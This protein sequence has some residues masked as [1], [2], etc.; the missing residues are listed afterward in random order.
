MP[1]LR[2][3]SL[4]ALA[5]IATTPAMAAVGPDQSGTAVSDV[6]VTARRLD[7]ARATIEPSLGASVYTLP[8]QTVQA[9]PGG[10]NNSLNQVLLQAPGVAQD[11]FGQLHVRDD[12][13]NLQYRLNN[14]I[15]PEGLSGFGQVLS[16]RLAASTELITGAVPAQYGLR[17][18]GIVNL[19]TKTG[20]FQNAGEASIYGGAHSEIE[21]SFEYGGS[22]GGTNFFVSGSYLHNDLGIESPD[23]SADPLH[24]KTDQ[25]QGFAYVDHILGPQSRISFILG[26][27]DQSFQ[28]PSR[29]GLSSSIDGF[30][31]GDGT[32]LVVDGVS[33]YP[34]ENVRSS[35]REGTQF[36][37]VSYL[38]TWKA[39]TLQVSGFVRYSTLTYRPDF[40]GELLFNGIAQFAAKRDIAGGV[41]V[42]GVYDL[43]D[44]HTLRAGFI[45][46]LDRSRS[47]TLSQVLPVD[48]LGVQ[49]TDGPLAVIDNSAKTEFEGG[50]YL[51]DEWK[52]IEGLTLNY[53]VRFDR[54]NAYRD[55]NA[56]SPRLNL[57]WQPF[58]GTTLHAGYARYFTPPPFELVANETVAKFVGTTAEPP[59][60]V[61]HL[62]NAETDNY[63]DLGAQQRFGPLTL[64]VDG[65]WRDA[66]NLIDEGQFGAPIILTPF[67]YAT[68]RIRGVELSSTYARGALSAWANLALERAL[69]RGI[70]SSEFNFNPGDVAYIATHFIHLDHDQAVTASAGAAY[71]FGRLKLSG[72]LLYGSGLRRSLVLADG[73][74][75]PNGGHVPGYLQVNLAANYRV[76]PHGL[77]VRFDVINL[78]DEKYEIRDG[79]GVGVGAPQWGPR[80]GLFIGL[81]KPF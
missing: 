68:G 76:A 66:K 40:M 79:S 38:H 71:K 20:A 81:S 11:S 18:A 6:V 60:L 39:A 7:A 63:Y 56:V 52:P 37:I 30:I 74:S 51:E 29:R 32:P 80:R 65:Y 2:T 64:G 67:N 12:H 28:I 69:G 13:G 9:L 57:V 50:L 41:Q 8:S 54:V 75:I 17:T 72:D 15:L 4:V 10:E 33:N 46:Q 25:L 70:V 16:P 5:A 34:S 43:N 3:A 73:A 49:T 22:H 31:Q 1:T 23:G 48:D 44:R 35:Q 78:F 14:V 59:N 21:P 62:P 27:S 47:R 36:G 53:G 55:Q 19:T 42:E 77:E 45:A 26:A 58:G 24:D 61:D